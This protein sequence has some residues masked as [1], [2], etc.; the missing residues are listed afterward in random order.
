VHS[1]AAGAATTLAVPDGT[2]VAN[3]IGSALRI[4]APDAATSSYLYRAPGST[5]GMKSSHTPDP[6]IERIWWTRPSQKFQ[7]PTTR[8]AWALGAHTA[9]DAPVMPSW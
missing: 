5:P 6:P 8:T 4:N 2:S 7:S 9:K 3:A 1:W